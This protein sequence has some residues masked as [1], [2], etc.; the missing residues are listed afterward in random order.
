MIVG[1]MWAGKTT[2]LHKE[3]LLHRENYKEVVLLKSA[4]DTRNEEDATDPWFRTHDTKL[5]PCQLIEDEDLPSLKIYA[6]PDCLVVLDEAMLPRKNLL[7]LVEHFLRVGQGD[8]W[9]GG[10]LSTSEGHPFG[11]FHQCARLAHE[12]THLR[13]RCG[14]K[15]CPY[16]ASETL[17]VGEKLDPVKVGDAGYSPRCASCWSQ[18][19]VVG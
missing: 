4:W 19:R 17:H 5:C 8:L 12:I 10:L 6:Q 15:G 9:L 18:M 2:R 14:T 13:A 7:D 1:P 3:V 16:P 11:E